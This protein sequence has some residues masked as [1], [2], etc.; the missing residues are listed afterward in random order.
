[1]TLGVLEN[2]GWHE[3]P[4]CRQAGIWH[5]YITEYAD[6]FFRQFVEPFIYRIICLGNAK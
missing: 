1:M 4:A 3:N 6:L 2:A 5:D